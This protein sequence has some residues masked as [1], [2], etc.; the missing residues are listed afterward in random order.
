MRNNFFII[1][2]EPTAIAESQCA[3]PVATRNRTNNIKPKN[4]TWDL[5]FAFLTIYIIDIIIIINE[6]MNIIVPLL[7]KFL[8]LY[9]YL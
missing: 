9:W 5:F 3:L 2:I 7:F 6:I 4:K 1:G 8:C